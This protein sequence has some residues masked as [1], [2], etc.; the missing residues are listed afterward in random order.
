MSIGWKFQVSV[1]WVDVLLWKEVDA[2]FAD[3]IVDVCADKEV[4]R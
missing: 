2:S 3:E 4:L 1:E